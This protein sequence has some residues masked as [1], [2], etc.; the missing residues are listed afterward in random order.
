MTTL[1]ARSVRT[2]TLLRHAKS[3]WKNQA[4]A[5]IE[6]PLNNRGRRA[7]D[8]MAARLVAHGVTFTHIL[9]SPARRSRETIMR[10]LLALPARNATI[11]FD[12]AFYIFEAQGLIDAL[13]RLDDNMLDVLIVGHNPA[14]EDAIN[15]LTGKRIQG[16]PTAAC[17]QLAIALPNWATLHEA[18]AELVWLLRPE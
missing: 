17:A 1:E 16:F 3:S 10:M 5:D 13:R 9:A 4:L 15:F 12:H 18:C 2:L 6:R 8:A 7:A 14:L 11:T